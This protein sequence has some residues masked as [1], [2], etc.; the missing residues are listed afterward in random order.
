MS[1][2]K[3]EWILAAVV[4]TVAAAFT[5]FCGISIANMTKARNQEEETTAAVEET[6]ETVTAETSESGAPPEETPQAA[7]EYIPTESEV[8][9]SSETA[10][11]AETVAASSLNALSADAINS[12]RGN[13][14]GTVTTFYTLPDRDA[15]NRPANIVQL[16]EQFKSKFQNVHIINDNDISSISICFILTVEFDSNT[17]SAIAALDQYGVKG[18]FFVDQAY[19][20][21]N[22][23]VIQ[24]LIANGHEIGS[25]GY[26]FPN[27][28]IASLSLEDQYQ[29]ILAM[30]MYMKD[31]FGYEMKKFY[32]GYEQYSE[33]TLALLTSM[34][35]SVVFYSINYPDYNHAEAIDANA[36]LADISSKLH[37]HAVISLH[38]T[39]AASIQILPGLIS[40]A[41]NSGYQ[42]TLI[43]Q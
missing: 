17:M 12:I 27:G 29:D 26:A 11:S 43:G 31:T 22:P 34:G 9:S 6:A 2:T 37:D 40:Q 33:Q 8:M 35:Y 14:D 28:G 13:Y 32:L 42:V 10:S 7:S 41:M 16:D 4:F 39:N 15:A 5:I 30:H 1:N 24:T 38:T 25:L 3:K 19:A 36:F 21:A 18:T 23:G 20:A